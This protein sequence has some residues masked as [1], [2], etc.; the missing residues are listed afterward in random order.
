MD[1]PFQNCI[2]HTENF[3]ASRARELLEYPH[4]M[5]YTLYDLQKFD[6]E[7]QKKAAHYLSKQEQEYL[8]R[9]TSGKR[10][11]EWLGGRF[12]AKYVASEIL[13]QNGKALPWSC[14]AVL[15]D[16]NG[17]PFLE[18]DKKKDDFP[19]ISI[20]HSGD[21]AVAMAVNK[22]LCGIDI[23]K[24]TDRVV[25][26]RERF[27]TPNEEAVARSFFCAAPANNSAALTRLW[28]AKEALRKVA[29]TASLPGFL[30]LELA[31]IN[32][33]ISRKDSNSWKFDFTWKQI[34]TGCRPGPEKLS[35]AV[36][37]I[38]DYALALTIRDDTL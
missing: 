10:R 4:A 16:V 33:G 15:A 36:S 5:A 20:S 14:L 37:R 1:F 21:L 23:Q 29:D 27:C 11:R 12:A 17:R 25:G 30:E 19:D 32:E 26:V 31:G 18:S 3:S 38:A 6:G 24:V 34:N 7:A 2:V 13:G 8:G 9:F 22:G 28:A 35:V